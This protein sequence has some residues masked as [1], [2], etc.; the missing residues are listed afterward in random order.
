[1]GWRCTKGKRMFKFLRR[2]KLDGYLIVSNQPP[3][4]RD[5]SSHLGPEAAKCK[6][7]TMRS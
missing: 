4:E 1:M 7:G 2:S 6:F 3:F 5:F